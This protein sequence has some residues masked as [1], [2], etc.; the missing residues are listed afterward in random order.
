MFGYIK[1]DI[2]ELKMK[3]NELYKAVYCG[4]CKTMGKCTGCASQ[5]TLSYDFAFLAL[6]R[7]V[8]D[9]IKGEIKMKSCG[10]HPFKKRPM[11]MQNE[12]LEFCAKSSVILTK[13]K[14]KDNINDSLGLSKLKAK[15][16]AL[17]PLF[18]KK[19][20]K[21]LKDLEEKV[22]ECINN[23]TALEKENS[24]SIDETANTFGA[25]LGILCSYG[26]NDDKARILYE[27]GYHLGKWIYVIDAIDD[28][29]DDIK[30]KSYNVIVNSYGNELNNS[31]RDALYCAMMLEL[32]CMS[33]SI[34]LLDFTNHNDVEG[35]IKNIIYSGMVK[36]TRKILML[37]ECNEC[38]S[39]T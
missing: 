33:K 9:D 20:D 3:E 12:A 13:L 36:T 11:L 32:D 1:P 28:M 22:A 31:H 29:A 16:A 23:L 10:V 6:I 21:N 15:T 5:L 24:D 34:E 19:T 7:M 38:K 30:K 18:F 25:L 35:I 2:P 39:D 17:L 8:S 4:L 14:L 26:H 37:D 27:I